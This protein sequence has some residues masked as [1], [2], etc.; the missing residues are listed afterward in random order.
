MPLGIHKRKAGADIGREG[1]QLQI[2][3]QLAVIA[4]LRLLQT[5]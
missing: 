4:L 1:E 5:V 3:P 2:A